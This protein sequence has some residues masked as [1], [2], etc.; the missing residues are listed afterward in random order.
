MTKGAAS[1]GGLPTHIKQLRGDT[2]AKGLTTKKVHCIEKYEHENSE[3]SGFLC[4]TYVCVRE[5]DRVW[6]E[7]N[8]S[9]W[10]VIH[11]QPCSFV[12]S[13]VNYNWFFCVT[14]L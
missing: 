10:S 4:V 2:T 6:R 3:C 1:K 8:E 7:W 5:R 14:S 9:I 12:P 11:C 13:S